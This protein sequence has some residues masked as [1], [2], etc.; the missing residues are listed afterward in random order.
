MA[1]MREFVREFLTEHRGRELDVLDVGAL[2][3]NGS[4]EHLIDDP[5]WRYTGLDM[6]P[7]RGVDVVV[8]DPYAWNNVASRQYDVVMSGQALEHVEFPWATMLEVARVAKP[9]ALIAVI[10]PSS[11]HEHRHPLDCYRFYPDGVA[12]LARWADL[13]VVQAR[14]VTGQTQF[15]DGS[16]AWNDTLLVARRPARY[17]LRGVRT[18]LK[19]RVL[20]AIVIAQSKRRATPGVA[21]LEH[22]GSPADVSKLGTG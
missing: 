21:D 20:R 10:V 15:K 14:Y 17:G 7:G 8:R 13:A 18:H 16:E 19:N 4:Y 9:G 11:G 2:D 1:L 3:V 12:A 6:S 5:N 22:S